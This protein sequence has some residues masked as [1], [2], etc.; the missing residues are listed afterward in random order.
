M[1]DDYDGPCA[2]APDTINGNGTITDGACAGRTITATGALSV[3]SGGA[4]SATSLSGATLT[5]QGSSVDVPSLSSAFGSVVV[6]ATGGAATIGTIN[7]VNGF[8]SVT[9]STSVTA[10][11]ALFSSYG[12]SAITA[13][14]GAVLVKDVTVSIGQVTITSTGGAITTDNVTASYE[15]NI[16]S[17]GAFAINTKA[18]TANNG[19]IKVDSG[20]T[21]TIVG[22]TK[23]TFYDIEL[24]AVNNLKTDIIEAGRDLSVTSSSGNVNTKDLTADQGTLK[25][26]ADIK[27]TI[28]GITKTNKYDIDLD[29]KNI[30]KTNAITSGSHIRVNSTDE[31]INITSTVDSNLDDT[32]GGNILL[33]ANKSIF[34]RSINTHGNTKAGSVRIVANKGGANTLFIVGTTATTNGVKGTITTNTVNGGGTNPS[35][36][37][38][39]ISIQNGGT[40]MS[41]GGITVVA[42][43]NLKV[44]ASNSKAGTIILDAKNGTLTLP[45]GTMNANAASGKQ[46]GSIV[47]MAKTVNTASG[48]IL[49]A[50]QTSAAPGSGHSISIA[51]ETLNLTGPTGLKIQTNG[52]G[53]TGFPALASLGP[54]GSTLVYSDDY[55]VFYPYWQLDNFAAT[56]TV[57]P[58]T[59]A[60]AAPLTM[61]SN[62][63]E[64]QVLASG[65]PLKFSNS[66]LTLQ[67]RGKLNHRVDVV[68]DGADDGSTNIM[69]DSTLS[70]VTLDANGVGGAGG[71]VRVYGDKI[72]LNATVFNITAIGPVTGNG[73]GGELYFR[74][75]AATLNPASKVS[76]KADAAT[77]GTGNAIV[78]A[79][80]NLSTPKAIIFFPGSVSV[81]IGTGNG[82]YSFSANGGMAGG[83]AGTIH[84]SSLPVRIMTADAITASAPGA[85][86]NGNGGEI[87]FNS[88]IAS[89][90][91]AATMSAVGKGTGKG[92]KF[93]A[94][95]Q[96]LD[97][98]ILQFVKVDGG[99]TVPTTQLNG[100]IRLNG[101]WCRQW[102]LT[103]GQAWPKTHWVCTDQSDNPSVPAALSLDTAPAD[104]AKSVAFDN[105]RARLANENNKAEIFVFAG[106]AGFNS[107]WFETLPSNAGGLTFK[108]SLG[109]TRIYVNPWQ[110]GSKG[111]PDNTQPFV[112]NEVREVA[113][114]ELG[115][116]VDRSF[117]GVGTL[118]SRDGLY[119]TFVIRDTNTLD[120]ADAAF[121]AV[122]RLPCTL[123]PNPAGGNFP[124]QI[125][126]AGVVDT[127]TGQNVCVGGQL[128]NA[129]ILGGWPPNTF[130]SQVLTTL[131]ASLWVPDPVTRPAWVEVH[132]QSF[133]YGAVG[134]QGGK[135]F[136]NKLL[137]NGYFPCLKSW[138][139]SERANAVPVGACALIPTP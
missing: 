121:N 6:N 81:D 9:A 70:N 124:G 98:D 134:N 19:Y 80:D 108:S 126:F 109:S 59:V 110:S 53:A 117:A 84:V 31:N 113:A 57:K 115:H 35:G 101:I 16:K 123:T 65:H 100:S 64:S 32:S 118:P 92:G 8:F 120:Y 133:G 60:G 23:S 138:A 22:L 68:F 139:T 2:G 71:K 132:A 99:T 102:K 136:S 83:N 30:V 21:L 49:S 15:L 52:K 78:G 122:R 66:A 116:A 45:S 74:S 112:Y 40:A 105:L 18:L 44:A 61:T 36:F 96:I 54:Q 129:L 73:N 5:V 93:T 76:F 46:A 95:H 114:H 111:D 127:V 87:F 72:D 82:Q 12:P 58:L 119:N 77:V 33:T 75:N 137:D 69:F 56:S 24:K 48:T 131:E 34:T 125:P 91:P 135:P 7:A 89:F 51:A 10:S 106:N 79:T 20:K 17:N 3:T 88:R 29:A 130:N 104:A 107:F 55:S 28:V 50:T 62:G 47:L 27:I 38:F 97:L 11:G 85:A 63:D 67:S 4:V 90:D 103:G 42:M 94:N 39:G 13:S 37:T 43:G 41:A 128:N 1:A 26:K 86:G 14:N 25:V